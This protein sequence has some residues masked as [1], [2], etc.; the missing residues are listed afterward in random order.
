MEELEK[1]LVQIETHLKEVTRLFSILREKVHNFKPQTA[2]RSPA[3]PS[4]AAPV[5]TPTDETLIVVEE[6]ASQTEEVETEREEEVDRSQLLSP[7]FELAK[8]TP[9]LFGQKEAKELSRAVQKEWTESDNDA[10]GYAKVVWLCAATRCRFA[11]ASS[12]PLQRLEELLSSAESALTKGYSI[13]WKKEQV[14]KE[15][16]QPVPVYANEPEATAVAVVEPAVKKDGHP[17]KV[18]RVALS[19][20][21]NH[22]VSEAVV[23]AI[24]ALSSVSPPNPEAS[25]DIYSF[26]RQFH[27][28]WLGMPK[29]LKPEHEQARLRDVLNALD[30]LTWR[31]KIRSSAINTCV[32]NILSTLKEMGF[33]EI[34]VPSG[35]KFDE[36]LSPSKFEREF[37]K[38]DAP[39]GTIVGVIRRGFVDASGTA[40]QKVLVAVSR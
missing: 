38:S 3:Q 5:K 28:W 29:A 35:R 34:Y 21:R 8:E 4:T 2:V 23:A 37:V 32:Q 6:K 40:V 7:I 9:G 33:K 17:V 11:L 19:V 30:L 1:L 25:R 31:Y 39:P 22:K 16:F 10:L 20:G 26:L 36:T 15:C 18:G 13:L 14:E 12:Q 24:R 27:S